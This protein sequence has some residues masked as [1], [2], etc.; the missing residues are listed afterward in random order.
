MEVLHQLTSIKKPHINHLLTRLI[1]A[2]I[3]NGVLSSSSSFVSLF[4]YFFLSPFISS[5]FFVFSFNPSLLCFTFIIIFSTTTGYSNDPEVS[6]VAGCC[7]GVYFD[8]FSH[9][10]PAVLKRCLQQQPPCNDNSLCSGKI[11]S[12]TTTTFSN[13]ISQRTLL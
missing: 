13:H 12:L 3:H 4:L 1:F 5:F 7:L 9:V 8:S 11:Y 6:M 10:H 2:V